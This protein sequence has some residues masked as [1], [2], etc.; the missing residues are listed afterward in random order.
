MK[1]PKCGFENK[2]YSHCPKCEENIKNE[3]TDKVKNVTDAI[4]EDIHDILNK[5]PEASFEF[6]IE[7]PDPELIK[8]IMGGIPSK[9]VDNTA[10]YLRFTPEE[11]KQALLGMIDVGFTVEEAYNELKETYKF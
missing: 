2:P 1:C 11:Y 3:M 8:F 5:K 6:V 10:E 7:N 9:K 4:Y